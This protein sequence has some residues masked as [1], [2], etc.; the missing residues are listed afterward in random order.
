MT[1]LGR[2][3]QRKKKKIRTRTAGKTRGGRSGKNVR[4]ARNAGRDRKD[5]CKVVSEVVT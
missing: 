2:K 3:V 1:Y 4:R 5:Q